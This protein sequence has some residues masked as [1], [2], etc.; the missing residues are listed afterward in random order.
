MACT[1][2]RIDVNNVWVRSI[3][4]FCRL[5]R[6]CNNINI[7]YSSIEQQL[8]FLKLFASFARFAMQLREKGDNLDYSHINLESPSLSGSVSFSEVSSASVTSQAWHEDSGMD[9]EMCH[10]LLKEL[11]V[12]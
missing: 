10:P 12:K 1:F 4:T 2:K 6:I 8:P 11:T 5:S 9:S 7:V 3:C